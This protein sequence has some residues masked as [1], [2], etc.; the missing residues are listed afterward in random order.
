MEVWNWKMI[1][2]STWWF[3]ASILIFRGVVE[4]CIDWCLFLFV[5]CRF[6]GRP[7]QNQYSCCSSLWILCRVRIDCLKL[8]KILKGSLG[9]VNQYINRSSAIYFSSWY[10][11]TLILITILE[12]TEHLPISDVHIYVFLKQVSNGNLHT[13]L[14]LPHLPHHVNPTLPRKIYPLPSN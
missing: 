4:I 1:S 2:F 8:L 9:S 6:S 13:A 14:D 12:H 10:I 5:P 11:I 7:F 3:L